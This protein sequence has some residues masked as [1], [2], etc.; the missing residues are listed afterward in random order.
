MI[1]PIKPTDTLAYAVAPLMNN[2]LGI[3]DA[4]LMWNGLCLASQ[5]FLPNLFFTLVVNGLL[6]YAISRGMSK[7]PPGF[8]P[9]KMSLIMGEWTHKKSII[10]AIARR[11][12]SQTARN[13]VQPHSPTS[14][15]NRYES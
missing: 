15:Y 3:G 6:V 11:F 8:L 9:Q 5:W 13:G 1:T 2:G 7:I 4:L 12:E 14:I 10:G